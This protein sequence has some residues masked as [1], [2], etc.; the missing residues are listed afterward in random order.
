[1]ELVA[2]DVFGLSAIRGLEIDDRDLSGVQPSN[3]ID[4][5]VDG[6]ARGDMHLDSLFREFRVGNLLAVSVEVAFDCLDTGVPQLLT[7]R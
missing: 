1:M 5:A 2:G 7:Q 3:E 6:D 4:A